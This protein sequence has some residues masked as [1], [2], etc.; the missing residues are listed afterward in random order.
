[1][2]DTGI[3]LNNGKA[4]L[5]EENSNSEILKTRSN[6]TQP[7]STVKAQR[8]CGHACDVTCGE[9]FWGVATIG[10]AEPLRE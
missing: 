7:I 10:D 1:L 4:M 6:L 9:P 5:T 2:K 8:R 3:V